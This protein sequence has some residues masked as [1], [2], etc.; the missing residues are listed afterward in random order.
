MREERRDRDVWE[1]HRDKDVREGRRDSD[2]REER[3]DREI[4][5]LVRI[6]PLVGEPLRPRAD[7]AAI[8]GEPE[9]RRL[10]LAMA[11]S[12]QVST[13]WRMRR[14]QHK[15]K[16]TELRWVAARD[17]ALQETRS[18]QLGSSFLPGLGQR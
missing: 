6:S 2:V 12:M 10:S 14:R 1:G 17:K 5:P 3:R 9:V 7:K 18:S 15:S 13:K 16:L 11:T 4:S 8:R